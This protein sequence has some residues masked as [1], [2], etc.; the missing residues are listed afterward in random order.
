MHRQR[1]HPTARLV[2][3][4][5]HMSSGLGGT[6]VTS[7]GVLPATKSLKACT[8]M[9][10]SRQTCQQWAGRQGRW[11]RLLGLFAAGQAVSAH[12]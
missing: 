6:G 1:L 3:M 5:Q 7:S 12:W 10:A 4:M 11:R 2:Y 8:L 9:P